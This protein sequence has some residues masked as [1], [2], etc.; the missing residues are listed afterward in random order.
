[1]SFLFPVRLNLHMIVHESSP[2]TSKVNLPLANDFL[3]V[4]VD[5]SGVP[6]ETALFVCCIEELIIVALD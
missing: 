4:T 5:V 1:M 2:I 3:R 6:V